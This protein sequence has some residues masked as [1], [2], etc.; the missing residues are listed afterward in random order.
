MTPACLSSL[1]S[2]G[3]RNEDTAHRDCHLV[4]SYSLN[5]QALRA[6]SGQALTLIPG[7]ASSREKLC[8][9]LRQ[10]CCRCCSGRSRY[11]RSGSLKISLSS[12]G[13][14]LSLERCSFRIKERKHLTIPPDLSRQVLEKVGGC[15]CLQHKFLDAWARKKDTDV[16]GKTP[17]F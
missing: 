15:K 16:W 13:V 9:C 4:F 6:N 12:R 2:R 11:C 17:N 14:S 8:H 7:S 5:K 3:H 1:G 10:G